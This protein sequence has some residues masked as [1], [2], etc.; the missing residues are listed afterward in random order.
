MREV[1][2]FCPLVTTRRSWLVAF[3]ETSADLAQNRRVNTLIAQQFAR[4]GPIRKVCSSLVPTQPVQRKR[5]PCPSHAAKLCE[6]AAPQ[7]ATHPVFEVLAR[8]PPGLQRPKHPRHWHTGSS[9]ST[10][11]GVAYIHATAGAGAE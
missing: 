10:K 4:V 6:T 5:A 2:A 1:F 9:T 11:A 3:S 8:P 7:T